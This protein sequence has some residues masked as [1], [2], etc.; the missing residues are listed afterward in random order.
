MLDKA[1]S[2]SGL[3]A[4]GSIYVVFLEHSKDDAAR[5]AHLHSE[6][7][8]HIKSELRAETEKHDSIGSS[9][10]LTHVFYSR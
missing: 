6:S 3:A 7:S 8:L 10:T 4:L 9:M 5:A 1:C 2:W